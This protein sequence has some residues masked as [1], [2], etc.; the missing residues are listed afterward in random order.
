MEKESLRKTLLKTKK[1]F[2]SENELKQWFDPLKITY[3]ENPP[4]IQVSF[5]H[6]FFKDWFITTFQEPFEEASRKLL[7]NHILFKYGD[8]SLVPKTYLTKQKYVTEEQSL[9]P[10]KEYFFEEYTFHSFIMNGKYNWIISILEKLIQQNTKKTSQNTTD[11]PIQLIILFGSQST[12]KTHLMLATKHKLSS[13]P[14]SNHAYITSDQFAE[15]FLKK[16]ICSFREHIQSLDTVLID[17]C[18]RFSVYPE[19]LGELRIVLDYFRDQKKILVLSG[20]DHPLTWGLPKEI[21][22]RLELGLWLELPIPDLDIRLRFAQHICKEKKYYQP[23]ENLLLV[24]QHCHNMR[25]IQGA[26]KRIA[27]HQTMLHK[28][29]L[30]K[31]I[32]ILIKQTGETTAISSETILMLVAEA[33]GV[34]SMDILGESRQKELVL[35]RQISM[36]LCRELLGYS[37]PTIGRIFGGKDHTTVIHSIKKIKLLQDNNRVVHSMIKELLQKCRYPLKQQ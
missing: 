13:T 21:Y 12:G 9:L 29:L 35:A 2:C 8:I 37:Y 14:Y 31:D 34:S 6:N 26:L 22:S 18:Q 23:K 10:N 30:E 20:T 19:A 32:L 17:D 28:D 7:G 4:G 16:T 3:E 27:L 24:A 36:Y 1:Y 11:D 25:S 5:P 33:Y 15:Q